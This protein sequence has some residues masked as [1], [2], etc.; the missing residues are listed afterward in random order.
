V[1]NDIFV[2]DAASRSGLYIA[3]GDVD[4]DGFADVV[5]TND[6]KVANGAEVRV[7]SGADLKTRTRTRRCWA[8][9]R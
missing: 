2:A 5:V 9:S 1:K 4:G 8:T 7:L 3:S 6:P